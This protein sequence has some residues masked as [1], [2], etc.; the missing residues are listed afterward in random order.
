MTNYYRRKAERAKYRRMTPQQR[1]E[2]DDSKMW[3]IIIFVIICLLICLATA[4]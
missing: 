4:L 2:Y 3:A 1:K